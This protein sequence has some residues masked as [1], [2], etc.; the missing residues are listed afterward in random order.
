MGAALPG[1]LV[2]A[3]RASPL[4]TALRR[5]FFAVT[6]LHSM[7]WFPWEL[8]DE[9]LGTAVGGGEG[10]RGACSIASK[11][12]SSSWYGPN[13]RGASASESDD[14]PF[15]GRWGTER[16]LKGPD[17]SRGRT[18]R[19]PGERPRCVGPF[20][21]AGVALV[22]VAPRRFGSGVTGVPDS[23]IA[24]Q[25]TRVSPASEG[26]GELSERPPSP[27]SDARLTSASSAAAPERARGWP[28]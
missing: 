14:P 22:L 4:G 28:A 11:A 27:P 17:C 24:R 7:V 25:G 5:P 1:P 21:I 19:A 9:L 10:G 16:E 26:G 8:V 13:V 18:A 6:C 12:S 15:C 2:A 20:P 23:G 3:G